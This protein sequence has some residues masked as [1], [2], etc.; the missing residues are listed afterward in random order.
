MSKRAP[1]KGK[2]AAP[3]AGGDENSG[4]NAPAPK[5]GAVSVGRSLEMELIPEIAMEDVV[6][7]LKMLNYEVQFCQKKRPFWTPLSRTY[8]ALPSPSNN[9]NEQF[10]YFTS[11]T[12]WL[13]NK[14]GSGYKA[15]QQFDDPNAAC[16]DILMELKKMGFAQPQWPPAKLK[17]GYGDAPVAVLYNLLDLVLA[18]SAVVFEKPIYQPDNYEDDADVED[19]GVEEKP[20]DI[21]DNFEADYDDDEEE[22]AYMGGI[23]AGGGGGGEKK[24]KTQEEEDEDDDRGLLESKVD[25]DEWRMELERVAPQLKITMVSDTKD[26]RSHLD[27][28]HMH[29]SAITKALPDGGAMLEK[30]RKPPTLHPAVHPLVSPP[31]RS[32]QAPRAPALAHLGAPPAPRAQALQPGHSGAPP[33]GKTARSLAAWARAMGF[34]DLAR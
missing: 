24:G 5:S 27:Q 19:D 17:Q 21:A 22:E 18:K 20:T 14:A 4:G 8:F 31:L 32:R 6:D 9:Q 1:S 16:T 15:P 23:R 30:V 29:H 7:K 28:T 3:P 13:L 12:A 2:A 34:P 11:L 26:W 33:P 10:F 25:A